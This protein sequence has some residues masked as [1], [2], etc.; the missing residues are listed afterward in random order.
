M[1]S[2]KALIETAS[3]PT[4][5]P[6]GTKAPEAPAP[7]PTGPNPST[8][9]EKTEKH[10]WGTW[11]DD[12][13]RA[14][15]T[16]SDPVPTAWHGGGGV[17]TVDYSHHSM[18]AHMG[19]NVSLKIGMS[20]SLNGPSQGDTF[21]S[22]ENIT[23]TRWDDVIVGDDKLI[24]NVLMGMQGRD[25]IYGE[26]G[27]DLII[28]GEGPDVMYGG[29]Q[30]DTFRFFYN[31]ARSLVGPDIIKDFDQDGDDIMEFVFDKPD[32]ATWRA[33]TWVHDGI[34][35]TMV[36]GTEQINEIPQ[37]RFIVFLEGVD[38]NDFGTDDIA[39]I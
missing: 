36:F 37:D 14:T 18:G 39:F 35:G 20:L 17:D 32:E 13:F 31:D 24:G 8:G 12:V 22:I 1:F 2:F 38:A 28:G 21:D 3:I 10:V 27:N 7:L 19:I 15:S 30:D 11:S 26:G 23:G 5:I 25:I 4:L 34:E 29:G 6:T 33:E 16:L 9:T